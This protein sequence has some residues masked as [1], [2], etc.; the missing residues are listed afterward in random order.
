MLKFRLPSPALVVSILALALALGG[1]AVAAGTGSDTKADTRLIHRLAPS[2]TVKRATVADRLRTLPSGESESG[3]FAAAADNTTANG[4]YLAF[5]LNYPRPLARPIKDSHIIDTFGPPFTDT[6]C[7]G[8]GQAA[9]GY[10][11]LYDTSAHNVKP[12]FGY[13]NDANFLQLRPSLGAIIYWQ[14]NGEDAYA[15]GEWTVTAR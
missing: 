10:L 7:P 14:E 11:C 2:L 6:H 12:A 15:G 9:P 8:F 5:G 13:S 3:I 1:T 4:N